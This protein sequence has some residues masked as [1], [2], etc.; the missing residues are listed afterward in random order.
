MKK[1]I[2]ASDVA[3]R[4]KKESVK[5]WI[6]DVSALRVSQGKIQLG[7]DGK[8]ISGDAVDVIVNNG[9]VMARCPHCGQHE[10]VSPREK[11]FFCME[12]G[13]DN[14]GEARPVEFPQDWARIEAALIARPIFPGPGLDEVQAVFRSRPVVR[15]LKRNWT[16]AISVETLLEENRR[17]GIGENQ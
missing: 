7:W 5:Q 4:D 8:M 14:S 3:K 10:Y 16:S 15:E 11:V 6:C 17:F 13:N 1:F 12:C 9:R 2:T